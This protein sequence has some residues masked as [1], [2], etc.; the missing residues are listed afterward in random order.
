VAS[1]G[2]FY[3]HR[4]TVVFMFVNFLIYNQK[5]W[6]E[7]VRA[8]ER[9]RTTTLRCVLVCSCELDRADEGGRRTN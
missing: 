6:R 3:L 8:S 2:S 9:I 4:A 5:E 7:R 1:A